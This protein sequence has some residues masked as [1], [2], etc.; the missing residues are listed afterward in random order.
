VSDSLKRYELLD[1]ANLT[2]KCIRIVLLLLLVHTHILIQLADEYAVMQHETFTLDDTGFW[3]RYVHGKNP[4]QSRVSYVSYGHRLLV[5]G[6]IKN[7]G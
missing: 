5:H 4:I 7:K 3:V 2:G 1:I 6:L